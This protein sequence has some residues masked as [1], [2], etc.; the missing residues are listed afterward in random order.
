[1]VL[2][3]GNKP[4][5]G[6]IN[7]GILYLGFHELREGIIRAALSYVIDA[8]DGSVTIWGK[9]V[10]PV[11]LNYDEYEIVVYPARP[12]LAVHDSNYDWVITGAYRQSICDTPFWLN[13]HMVSKQHCTQ[14][15]VCAQ[16]DELI[17]VYDS[18]LCAEKVLVLPQ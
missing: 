12:F 1:M 17:E 14:L 18:I 13:A 2:I 15:Y 5:Q 6:W 16:G 7:D 3:H 10:H 11:R 9:T 4:V 8:F